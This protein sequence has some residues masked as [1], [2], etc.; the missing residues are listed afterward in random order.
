MPN[1]G[2]ITQPGAIGAELQTVI[3][4]LQ[5]VVIAIGSLHQTVD[6]LNGLNSTLVIGGAAAVIS[7]VPGRLCE[8]NV[9]VAG[10][11]GLIY[12]ANTAVTTTP[13]MAIPAA[14][15]VTTT[16]V[17]VY[18]GIYVVPGAGQKVVVTYS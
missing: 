10:A 9:V 8:I 18:N 2:P 12:D 13:I 1:P 5:N 17:N 7:A 4:T 14:I 11:A 15:G 16:K 3:A 6:Q